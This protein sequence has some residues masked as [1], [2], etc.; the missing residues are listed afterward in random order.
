MF[1]FNPKKTAV[2]AHRGDSGNAPENTLS[3]IKS[4]LNLKVDMIE[5]DVHLSKDSVP[6]VI[7]DHTLERT[8]NGKGKV[9]NYTI[10]DLKKLDAGSWYSKKY[11]NEQIPT[12]EEVLNLTKGNCVL[13]IEIKNGSSTYPEIE[14]IV[15]NKI[16]E[17]NA[18]KYCIIQSFDDEVLNNLDQL[19]CTVEIQKLVTGN[20]PF[21]PMHLVDTK[22]KFGSILKYKK[23][24]AINPNFKFVDRNIT[25][26]IH[27]FG[28]KI[29]VWTVNDQNEMSR[30]ID[31][32]VDGIITNFPEKLIALNKK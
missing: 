12:L 27:D 13:L 30:L 7:H 1:A 16:K 11:S 21:L 23:V 15:L 6:V 32:G 10:N 8:T 14:K 26:K 24:S 29:F 2:I 17:N 5:I 28:K 20:I 22:L 18:E 25:K 31:C 3:A 4:A 9:K 19:K